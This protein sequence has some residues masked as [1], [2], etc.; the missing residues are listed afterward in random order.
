MTNNNEKR[1]IRRKAVKLVVRD[2]HL[3][4]RKK[5]RNVVRKTKYESLPYDINFI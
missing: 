1:S 4:Y 2:W 5:D 3:L